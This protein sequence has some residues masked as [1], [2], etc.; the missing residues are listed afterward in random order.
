[1]KKRFWPF[2]SLI[3]ESDKPEGKKYDGPQDF[4]TITVEINMINSLGPKRLLKT[5]IS[6]KKAIIRV[7]KQC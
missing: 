7:K 3:I 1:M 6:A 4:L 5:Q 2:L